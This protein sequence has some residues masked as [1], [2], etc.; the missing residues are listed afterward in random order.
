MSDLLHKRRE[1]ILRLALRQGKRRRWQRRWPRLLCVLAV[2]GVGVWEL[3]Q[4]RPAE[5]AERR[6]SAVV[7]TSPVE[8]P[9][10]TIVWFGTDPTIAQRLALK[11]EKPRWEII[12]DQQ[13]VELMAEAGHPVSLI[14]TGGRTIMLARNDG[15]SAYQRGSRNSASPM[16]GEII[17]PNSLLPQ[18]N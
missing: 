15:I 5:P 11:P 16:D 8:K 3:R 18:G 2:A 6:Q 4:M 7:R 9:A 14:R 10:G 1:E 12:D 13:F 17:W